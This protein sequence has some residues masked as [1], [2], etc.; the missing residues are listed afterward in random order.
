MAIISD[1]HEISN[2]NGIDDINFMINN[3]KKLNLFFWN[4]FFLFPS[5]LQNLKP[6]GMYWMIKM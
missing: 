1:S 2:V 5:G 4:S 6:R 3:P